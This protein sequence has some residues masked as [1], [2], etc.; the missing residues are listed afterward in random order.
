[1][2]N[3]ISHKCSCERGYTPVTQVIMMM[4]MVMMMMLQG[5]GGRLVCRRVEGQQGYTWT[6]E[7][8]AN[9]SS[10]VTG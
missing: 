1:M 4:M 6:R 7:T 5:E 10:V 2:C 9:I 8:G 3:P